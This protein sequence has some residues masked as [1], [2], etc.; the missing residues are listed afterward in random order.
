M[1][2]RGAVLARVGGSNV[3]WDSAVTE[4]FRRTAEREGGSGVV[5]TWSQ[6][7]RCWQLPDRF[8]RWHPGFLLRTHQGCVFFLPQEFSQHHA[9]ATQ[10]GL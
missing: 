9:V 10:G 1:G 4:K 2:K 8:L 6:H 3:Q 7:A 5:F